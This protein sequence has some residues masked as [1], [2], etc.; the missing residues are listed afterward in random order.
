MYQG[1]EDVYRALQAG[2]AACLFKDTLS[3]DLIRV[4]R[5]VCAGRSPRAPHIEALLQER[6]R[7]PALTPREIQIIAL[8]AEGMRDR[9]IAR[10]LSIS[11]E[12]I[13]VHMRNIFAKL[14]VNDRISAVNLAMRRGVI[15]LD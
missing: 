7:R 1:D 9:E 4:V 13:G 6:A 5:D 2:A 15:H 14:D 10:V 11:A 3:T 12:T 8:V